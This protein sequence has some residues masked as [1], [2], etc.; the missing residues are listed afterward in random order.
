MVLLFSNLL[1]EKDYFVNVGN[2]P[3]KR[4]TVLESSEMENILHRLAEEISSQRDLSRLA[5]V[6]IHTRGVHLAERLLKIIEDKRSSR[7]VIGNIDINLYRDDW[8]RIAHHPQVRG[9]NIPFPM[10]NKEI[11]LVD[12]VLFTGRTIRAAMEALMDYGRPD[13]IELCVLID[14][15]NREL[16]IQANYTGMHIDTHKDE[17]INVLITEIDGDDRV[18]LLTP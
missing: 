1:Y 6:G 8:T 15:G 7:V 16:P 11:V 18:D 10:D 4:R 2:R 5:L 3:M 13:R 12:D 17:S 9:S 14:R